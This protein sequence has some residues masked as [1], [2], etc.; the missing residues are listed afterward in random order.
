M[1]MSR[2]ILVVD[3]EE[4][5]RRLAGL[6]LRD[7]GYRVLEAADGRRALEV[8]ARHAPDLVVLDLVMPEMEGAETI[9][10][11]RRARPGLRVLAISGVVG[12]DFYLHAAKM[13]GASDTLRKP[14]SRE[15]LLRA[16]EPLLD[17]EGAA[18]A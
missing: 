6:Y 8:V 17:G 4:E 3:D 12:A 2:T 1:S 15:Q 18:G 14:F 16:I 9:Q 10:E 11:L 7:A 13:L 5:V